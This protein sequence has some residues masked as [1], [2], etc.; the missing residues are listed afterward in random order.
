MSVPSLPRPEMSPMRA[1]KTASMACC[2]AGPACAPAC[3]AACQRSRTSCHSRQ[4]SR[5]LGATP[6]SCSTR[7]SVSA[8]AASM[9]C[10]RW[11]L[12][13]TPSAINGSSS[14][15]SRVQA[16][17]AQFG[18]AGQRVAGL[19]QLE[20]LVE[21]PRRRHVVEQRGHL[22]D[23]R[24]RGRLDIE[25]E[26]GGESHRT[27]DA[28]RILAVARDRVADHAQRALLDVLDAAV[29]VDDDLRHRVVVHRIDREVASRGVLDLRPP[30]VVAQ[31]AAGGVD[32]VALAGEF[33]PGR[34]LVAFDLFG[35]FGLEVGAKRRHLDH[36]VVTAAAED[37]MHDAKASAD[38]E[39]AAEQALHL[40]GRGVGGD[41]EVLRPCARPAGREPRRRRCRPRGLPPAACAPP[42]RRA[43]RATRGRCHARWPA[44]RRACRAGC[45]RPCPRACG[46][47]PSS[48]SMNLRIMLVLL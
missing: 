17:L 5:K 15:N 35:L 16:L 25:A 39:G 36:L 40:L 24:P 38:D 46:A 18:H 12:C 37:H 45:V 27:D 31:H 44:L 20:Q 13:L 22:A 2:S 29:V 23:R 6:L 30:D 28:H 11:F 7:A 33:A 48:L 21:Q 32:D 47:L 41:V 19:Q 34:L 26:L 8:S 14:G 4:A 9:N 42:S 3:R 1:S 43:R 10:T